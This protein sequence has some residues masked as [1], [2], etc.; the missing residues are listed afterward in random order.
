V[1][2]RRG[3]VAAAL[4]QKD[5]RPQR[6]GDDILVKPETIAARLPQLTNR[7]LVAGDALERHERALLQALAPWGGA[8]PPQEWWPRAAVAGMLGRVRLLAGERAD[9]LHLA[10]VYMRRPEASAYTG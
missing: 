9:P 7:V 5:E 4:F 10:P 6:L 1:D 8:A 2:A 3:E